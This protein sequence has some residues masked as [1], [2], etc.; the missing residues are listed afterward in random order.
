MNR[1]ATLLRSLRIVILLSV[2]AAA[3]A[4]ER[5]ETGDAADS[6]AVG[7]GGSG[8]AAATT[9]GSGESKPFAFTAA[10]LEAYERGLAREV[11]LVRAAQERQRTATTPQ[12]RGEAMQAQWEDATIPE[13]AK[14]AGLPVERYRSVRQTVNRTLQTL[15]FQ[16]KIDGPM[17][18]DTSRATP[19]MRRMLASDPLAELPAESAAALRARLDRIVKLWGGYVEMTAVGG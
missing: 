12:A 13:G 9:S 14:N 5:A 2:T 10:D 6:G 4:G 16:G 3:C 8:D 15:D 17:S 18:L 19:E 7:G 11:E 1:R